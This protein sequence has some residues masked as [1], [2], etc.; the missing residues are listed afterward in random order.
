[1]VEILVG[2]IYVATKNNMVGVVC[3]RIVDN[4]VLLRLVVV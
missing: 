2:V 4:F 1:M 3:G